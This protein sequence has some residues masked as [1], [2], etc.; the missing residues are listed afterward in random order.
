M[1]GEVCRVGGEVFRVG[2]HVW[3]YD[4]DI[5]CTGNYNI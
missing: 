1:G 3:P 4:D 2:G 5:L